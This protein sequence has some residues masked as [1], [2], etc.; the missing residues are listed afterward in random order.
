M[1]NPSPLFPA[2]DQIIDFF[3]TKWSEKSAKIDLKSDDEKNAYLNKGAVMLERFYKKNQPWNFNVLD[4]ESRFEVPLKD[5]EGSETHLLAGIIDRIDKIDDQNYE[6][7]DYKTSKR[8]PSQERL[9]QNLQ[10]SLYNLGLIKRWPHLTDKNIRLTLYFLPSGEALSTRRAPED[11]EHT[12]KEIIAIIHDIKRHEQANNWPVHDSP[13]CAI[14][15]YRTICPMW[16]HLYR[17]KA[18]NISEENIKETLA[19][20][21]NI[22]FQNQENNAQLKLLQ[23]NLA[24]YM[25]SQGLG[26]LFNDVGYVTRAVKS[27]SVYDF[28]LIKPILESLGHWDDIL[29]ID[30]RKFEKIATS[31]PIDL[32]T[33]IKE[34]ITGIKERETIT[35][36]RK[37][38]I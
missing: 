11:L 37:K 6:I 8:M 3:K 24:D 34:A 35:A 19:E 25:R 22:K 33:Q 18:E 16:K 20:F 4:L 32:Q 31:L 14:F 12:K 27:S 26:R 30:E 17:A 7:I 13:L 15:P 2:F 10:L 23:Q 29:K 9:D 5:A 21:L 36:H 38:L 1:F 28:T